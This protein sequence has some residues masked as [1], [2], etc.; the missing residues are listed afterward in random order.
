MSAT[1]LLTSNSAGAAEATPFTRSPEQLPNPPCGDQLRLQKQ[2]DSVLKG[3][4]GVAVQEAVSSIFTNLALLCDT[5][6]IV[7]INASQGGPLPVTLALFSL[8]ESE[9]KTLIRFI[10][11]GIPKI[12]SIKGSLRQVLD[13]TSFALRHELKRVF[14]H[15]LSGLNRELNKNQ[16]R[17]DVMRAHGLLSN[18][19]QQSIIALA[20]V[21]NPS[22]SAESLFDDYRDRLEQSTML[23]RDLSSLME[24]ARRAAENRDDEA[25]DLLLRDL[26]AFCHG[27]MHYLMYKDWDEFEDIAR[28]VMT[29]YGS[30][31]HSFMLHCFATYLEALI[32]Q[33]QMRAVLN[34]QSTTLKEE[35]PSKRAR[36]RA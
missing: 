32:N 9:S 35:R 36:K 2:L 29:S 17:A 15:E 22:I 18:C 34:D 11:R 8:I 21:F 23:L 16:L 14:G 33:V 3:I 19:F 5:L 24:L 30:A 31:R 27:S 25:N 7:E 4:K 6:R 13:G 1:N 12:K 10:E 28:E 20:Q 26:R